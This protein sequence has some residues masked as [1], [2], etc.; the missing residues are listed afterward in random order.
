MAVRGRQMTT[1]RMFGAFSP[2]ILSTS[3]WPC[4]TSGVWSRSTSSAAKCRSLGLGT[5][6]REATNSMTWTAV[7]ISI[8]GEALAQ[9]GGAVV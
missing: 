9:F 5:L 7:T 2:G 1:A 8:E 6:P 4:D 3:R